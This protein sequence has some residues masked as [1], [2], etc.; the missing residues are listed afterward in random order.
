VQFIQVTDVAEN[1]Y[2]TYGLQCALP[3]IRPYWVTR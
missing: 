3:N 2:H 1:A